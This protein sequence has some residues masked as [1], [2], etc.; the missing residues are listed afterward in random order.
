M[1]RV[2]I[3]MLDSEMPSHPGS[4]QGQFVAAELAKINRQ[5]YPWVVACMHRMMVA[6]STYSNPVVGDVENMERLQSDY[7]ELFK[8]FK[9]NLVVSGHEHAYARTCPWYKGD[10]VPTSS[11][12]VDISSSR[13]VLAGSSS[14]TSDTTGDTSD[15]RS[16]TGDTSSWQFW[17]RWRSIFLRGSSSSSSSGG[18][19]S[20]AAK[21]ATVVYKVKSLKLP[22]A[23][24][25]VLAGHAGA[26]FTASLP[27]PL[28]AW[29]EFAT[30]AKNG[31][32]RVT[33][34]NST[35]L[36]ES[37]STDDGTIM[38]AVQLAL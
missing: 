2:F 33:A 26:G 25:Y 24:V 21:Q 19:S 38:D 37:V 11:E 32:L 22:S 14:S 16:D 10:C 1:G 36:V 9:V 31:Y 29:T 3:L 20:T 30:Q 17:K 18:R 7:E 13:V 15:T 5:Q 23:P 27:A 6:P 34:T 12:L 28:P 35:L 4:P 8:K